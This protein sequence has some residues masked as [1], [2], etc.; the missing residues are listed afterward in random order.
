MTRIQ[1]TD[2]FYL[3]EFVPKE[4]FNQW[5]DKARYFIDP[6][7]PVLMQAVRDH[8]GKSMTINNWYHAGQFNN[9]GFR[10]PHSETGGAL[11][12]H[13]MGRATDSNVEGL[14]SDE[15]AKEIIKEFKKFKPY[16][17]TTIENPAF[18]KGWTHLDIRWTGLDTI[19]QVNP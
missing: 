7:I 11:S 18:T 14:T 6:K 10:H 15:V 2:N 17:L 1:L 16:G 3:D 13:K 12:Q 19:L 5:G 8:F 4:I 9:R